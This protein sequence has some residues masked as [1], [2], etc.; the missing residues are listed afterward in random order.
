MTGDRFV[1]DCCDASLL[2]HLGARGSLVSGFFLTASRFAR[3]DAPL[4]RRAT[5]VANDNAILCVVLS[6]KV[7]L[8]YAWQKHNGKLQ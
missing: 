6:P 3:A 7:T 1:G 4:P 5:A 8:T 2:V